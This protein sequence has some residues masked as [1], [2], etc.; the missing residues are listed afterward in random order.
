MSARKKTTKRAKLVRKEKPGG[1]ARAK[2]A[3]VSRSLGVRKPTGKKQARDGDG[4]PAARS[5]EKGRVGAHLTARE[6]RLVSCKLPGQ[7][8]IHGVSCEWCRKNGGTC[9]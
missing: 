6:A 4:G 9:V 7:G 1:T 8:I 3:A 2:K 5:E